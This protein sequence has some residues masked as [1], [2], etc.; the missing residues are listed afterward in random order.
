MTLARAVSGP[1]HAGSGQTCSGKVRVESGSF[2]MEERPALGDHER[3]SEHVTE[4]PTVK[5]RLER[6]RSNRMLAGVCGGLA[7]YFD[8]N[9]AF[10]RVGFVVLTLLGGAGVLI[11]IAAAL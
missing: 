9:P 6:S 3:M 2:R 1:A 4:Q 8:L 10:Y 7:R 11:Y 5:Q